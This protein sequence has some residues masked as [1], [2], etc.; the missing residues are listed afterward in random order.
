MTEKY[1]LNQLMTIKENRYDAALL[2]LEKRKESLK[3]AITELEKLE[4]ARDEVLRHKQDKLKKL[5]QELD[6]GTTTDK[7]TQA[8][9]YLEV[10]EENLQKEERKVAAQQKVV[11]KKEQEVEQAKALVLERE[12]DLE[13]L[14][15]HK[16]T[17][18]KEENY[19]SNRQE[20]KEQ[21]EL[22]SASHTLKKI[23]K[24]RDSR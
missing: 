10:V 24:R 11:E 1:P 15:E 12:K 17:W 19:R 5:R 8:K 13:K 2:E 4:K 18:E 6:E 16:K 20:E 7:I 9:N 3:Q 21:D 23:E 14:K 22:G